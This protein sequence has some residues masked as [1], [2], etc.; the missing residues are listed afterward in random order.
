MSCGW[1]TSINNNGKRGR[2]LKE[3][4]RM[5]EVVMFEMLEKKEKKTPRKEGGDTRGP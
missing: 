2:G 1:S 3:I 5:L 4:L